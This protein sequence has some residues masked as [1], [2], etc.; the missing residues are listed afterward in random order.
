MHG[1]KTMQQIN[2]VTNLT[3]FE[4]L[5]VALE[6]AGVKIAT[7]AAYMGVSAPAVS[8]MLRQPTI[9]PHRHDQLTA[10]GISPELLPRPEYITPGPKPQ[11]DDSLG[12]AA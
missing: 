8:R 12:E 11:A 9:A 3:R 7:I 5:G 10:F 2:P 6:R 1:G 4:K